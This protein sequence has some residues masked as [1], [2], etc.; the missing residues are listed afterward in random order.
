MLSIT[1]GAIVVD[2]LLTESV[3]RRILNE[4]REPI[5][6]S[7]SK[8]TTGITD[9]VLQCAGVTSAIDLPPPE[10]EPTFLPSFSPFSWLGGEEEN[11]SLACV[12]LTE[13]LRAAGAVIRA[14]GYKVVDVHRRN[15]LSVQLGRYAF[16]GKTDALVVPF[17]QSDEVLVM[18]QG[19]I[20]VDFKIDAA[21]FD[22][23]H[24]QAVAELLTASSLA[25]HN[26]MVVFTDLNCAGHILRAEGSTLMC[27]RGCSVKQTVAIMVEYLATL[28]SAELVVSPD[29]DRIPGPAPAKKARRDFVDRVHG[30]LPTNELLME[31]LASC[32]DGTIEGWMRAREVAYAGLGVGVEAES[33]LPSRP[34]G[35]PREEYAFY[36]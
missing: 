10:L 14:G 6:V 32:G 36:S 12:R 26:V 16:K 23:L 27:W 9:I 33:D 18:S 22:T 24:G 31:Q 29:D 19:R 17:S 2:A 7:I 35:H 1:P 4:E 3:L 15:L 11:A 25:V 34:E 28:C 20:I 8:A 13:Y 30:L 21:S 5:P